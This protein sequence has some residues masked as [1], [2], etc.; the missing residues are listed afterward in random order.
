MLMAARRRDGSVNHRR[1][2]SG[3][4]QPKAGRGSRQDVK[5]V[6][7]TMM[8]K[9]ADNLDGGLGLGGWEGGSES[10]AKR[11]ASDPLNK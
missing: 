8:N 10:R 7:N 9:R 3:N 11:S 1:L 6:T 2:S 5:K 4:Q